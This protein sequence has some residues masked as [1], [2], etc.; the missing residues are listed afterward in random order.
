LSLRA[1]PLRADRRGRPARPIACRRGAECEGS[2]AEEAAH[3]QRGCFAPS[4]R[5][6]IAAS[7]VNGVSRA[8]SGRWTGL[9][10]I[11]ISGVVWMVEICHN[12][13]SRYDR[14]QELPVM[15]NSTESGSPLGCF[16]GQPLPGYTTAWWRFC[17]PGITGRRTEE[18]PQLRVKDLDFVRGEITVRDGKG[19]KDRVTLLPDVLRQPLQDHLRRV[20]RTARSRFE[21][22]IGPIAAPECPDSKAS[23]CRREEWRRGSA[24]LRYEVIEVRNTGRRY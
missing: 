10:A 19:Q 6:P 12:S 17:E 2:G 22:G 21:K 11:A 3:S 16:R 8:L 24:R 15:N 18:D 14:L 20:S 5:L 1:G 23:E 7:V 4:E 9:F 13:R